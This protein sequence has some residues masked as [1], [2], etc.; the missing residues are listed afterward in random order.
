MLWIVC[1]PRSHGSYFDMAT[2]IDQL[3]QADSD[4]EIDRRLQW[5]EQNTE[6]FD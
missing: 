1:G 5:L 6:R 2:I 4:I 3:I